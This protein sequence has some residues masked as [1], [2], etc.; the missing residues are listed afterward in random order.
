MYIKQS[1]LLNS[2]SMY[3]SSLQCKGRLD[4]WDRR[5]GQIECLQDAFRAKKPIEHC[6]D[7]QKRAGSRGDSD[8]VTK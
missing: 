4:T 8:T 2:A 5:E 7:F 1:T 6:T 3:D